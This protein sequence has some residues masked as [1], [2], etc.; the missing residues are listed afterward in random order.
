[1]PFL[2]KYCGLIWPQKNIIQFYFEKKKTNT[3][4][5]AIKCRRTRTGHNNAIAYKYRVQSD[6]L[7]VYSYQLGADRLL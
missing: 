7:G 4:I 6:F 2:Y 3:F 5:P 1:M